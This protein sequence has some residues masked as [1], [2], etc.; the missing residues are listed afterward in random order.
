MKAKPL[1]HLSCQNCRKEV[2]ELLLSK[3]SDI[4]GRDNSGKTPLHLSSQNGAREIVELLLS[5]GADIN[6]KDSEG[7]NSSSSFCS[8]LS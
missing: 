5:K 4:N 6:S 1:C 3:G 2:A 7:K 8:E